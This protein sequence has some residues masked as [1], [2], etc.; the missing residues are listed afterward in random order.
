M[1]NL[2]SS[3]PQTRTTHSA[4]LREKA[5]AY[6]DKHYKRLEKNGVLPNKFT[7]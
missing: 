5:I 3:K 1:L 4:D 2:F 6:L 7:C